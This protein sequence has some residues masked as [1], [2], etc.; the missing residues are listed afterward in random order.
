MTGHKPDMSGDNQPDR[1][2]HTPIGVSGM[3]GVRDAATTSLAQCWAM[4]R[5]PSQLG[6][7]N[8]VVVAPNGRR[9]HLGHD[10][11]RLARNSD[12]K[13]LA[14]RNPA[15]MA[16]VVSTLTPMD[17]EQD[18]PDS[19]TRDTHETNHPRLAAQQEQ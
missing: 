16:W 17:L 8:R 11:S 3:S 10:G 13:R 19:G 6:W 15:V 7:A 14:R 1:H 9:Y 5:R 12:A 4:Y 2:G 18:V